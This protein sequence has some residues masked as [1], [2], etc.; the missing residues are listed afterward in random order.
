ALVALIAIGCNQG[1]SQIRPKAAAELQCPESE[2]RVRTQRRTHAQRVYADIAETP[3]HKLASGCGREAMY[4]IQC[5][6]GASKKSGSCDWLSVNELKTEH[7]LRRASY[8][9]QCDPKQLQ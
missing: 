5:P 9:M 6:P 7:L 3:E 2:I 4:V 1:S 8:D